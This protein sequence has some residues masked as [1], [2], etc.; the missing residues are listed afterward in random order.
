MSRNYLGFKGLW[1]VN[2]IITLDTRREKQ[3]STGRCPRNFLL[4]AI[5]KLSERAFVAGTPTGRPRDT[6]RP[7][8]L[9]DFFLY[10]PFL[11]PRIV[12]PQNFPRF[13]PSDISHFKPSCIQNFKTFSGCMADFLRLS[14]ANVGGFWQNRARDCNNTKKKMNAFRGVFWGS[15]GFYTLYGESMIASPRFSG[16]TNSG[17]SKWG[18]SKWG[19]EVLVHNCPR[20]PTIVVIL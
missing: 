11:L 7:E 8:T 9:C 14:D 2:P 15:E 6:G 17:K 1:Q 13:S 18:L 12:S 16:V 10:V 20:L 4:F 3:G 19:L 5:E